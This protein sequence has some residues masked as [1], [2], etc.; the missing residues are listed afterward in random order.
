M[1]PEIMRSF[2]IARDLRR[3]SGSMPDEAT[4][5]YNGIK[6]DV[7]S[8]GEGVEGMH[9]LRALTFKCGQGLKQGCSK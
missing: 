2:V 5:M 6:A 4:Y 9:G 8:M 3:G 7:Y 1:S